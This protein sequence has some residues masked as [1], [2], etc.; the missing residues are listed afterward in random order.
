MKVSDLEFSQ[1]LSYIFLLWLILTSI[2][3]FQNLNIIT[4]VFFI[5]AF[6]KLLSLNMALV[7]FQVW[8]LCQN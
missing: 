7:T 3:L 2:I 8:S 1:D 6:S 4:S 5:S